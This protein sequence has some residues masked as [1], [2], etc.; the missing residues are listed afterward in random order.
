MS[1]QPPPTSAERVAARH[2]TTASTSKQLV[3]LA[4][5][6]LGAATIAA[7]LSTVSE[8]SNPLWV[9]PV[10]FSGFVCFVG[11]LSTGTW[12]VQSRIAGKPSPRVTSGVFVASVL[13]VGGLVA[14]ACN[15]ARAT[16]LVPL[17]AAA[18]VVLLSALSRW[19]RHARSSR[20]ERLRHGSR[21][22]ATVTDDGLAE[23]PDT[24]NV[25]LATITVSF[26]D[27]SGTARWVTV[28]AAQSPGR[29]IAVGDEVDLWFDPSVPGDASRIVVEHDN[30]S[31]RIIPGGV[32]ARS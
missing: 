10:I 30:G 1:T 11:L 13:L 6:A 27:H 14:L 21:V 20:Q 9:V 22:S 8:T 16:Y 17:A 24:P 4:A 32:S 29:P 12:T 7:V 23:F 3:V 15:T 2:Q 5:G 18:V 19:R 26:R 25:K 28:P 31:S